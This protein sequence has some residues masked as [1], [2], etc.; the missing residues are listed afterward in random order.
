M[1][2][3]NGLGTGVWRSKHLPCATSIANA[4]WKSFAIQ[5][6][7]QLGYKV[8]VWVDVYLVWA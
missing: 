5:Q 1:Q 2:V 7:V 6:K 3:A 8:M 4:L